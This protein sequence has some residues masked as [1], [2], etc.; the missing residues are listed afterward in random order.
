MRKL[1]PALI[2]LLCPLLGRADEFHYNDVFLGV[3]AAGL[4]GTMI[5]LADDPSAAWY[6]PAGIAHADHEMVSLSGTVVLRRVLTVDNYL[7]SALDL[8]ST[9]V[10]SPA[11]VTTTPFLSGR[12]AFAGLSPG[13]DAYRVNSELDAPPAES[14]LKTARLS[15]ER[16]DSTYLVGVA[17]GQQVGKD[18]D[19][20]AAAYYVFRNYR[21]HRSDFRQYLAPLAD[22]S[23]AFQQIFDEQGVSHGLML[24]AGL[25]WHPGGAHGPF[26]LGVTARTGA[27]VSTSAFL[28]EEVFVGT[29]SAV[30]PGTIDYQRQQTTSRQDAGSRIPP[31]LG[32]GV[33]W[34]LRPGWTL[35]ADGTLHGFVEYEALGRS[36]SKLATANGSLGTELRLIP[37]FT[38][39]A[40]AF[41]NRTSAPRELSSNSLRPDS[42]DQYGAAAGCT[43]EGRYHAISLAAKY[44]VMNGQTSVPSSATGY[45][46]RYEV[47]PVRGHEFGVSFGGSYYF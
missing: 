36:V 41:T 2:L 38:F 14:G 45:E 28:Q 33:S 15:R 47:L 30:Q 20:G 40:G 9:S 26:R 18:L 11:S 21:E 16:A 25:L 23:V 29:P 17:Y 35:V 7:G 4:G 13:E 1:F 44:A 32:V 19:L 8:D 22:G 37:D 42:W 3:R 10:F 31:S 34:R 6:N 5:G 43:F 39:R 46:V 12:L 24:V 27:N